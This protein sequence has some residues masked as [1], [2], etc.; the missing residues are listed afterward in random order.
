MIKKSARLPL[1]KL[2][3]SFFNEKAAL[4]YLL[5]FAI[6][7]GIATFI[8][9]DFGTDAAQK[10]VYKAFWFEVL[11]VL[12]SGTLIRNTIHY[13]FVQRKRWSLLLFHMAMVIIII[14]AGLTRY[15]GFEGMMG[16]RQDEQ[17]DTFLSADSLRSG[18]FSILA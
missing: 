5:A 3:S 6:A 18:I 4:V 12:F 2:W 9:N 16:I 1:L 10:M 14:G 7:I 8:E 11:L 15:M 17:S 13:R